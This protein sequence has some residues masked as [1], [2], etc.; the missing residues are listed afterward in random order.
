MTSRLLRSGLL[1]NS[2]SPWKSVEGLWDTRFP[3]C[4]GLVLDGPMFS[5]VCALPSPISAEDCSSLFDRF[6][7]TMAQSDSS[8]ACLSAVWRKAFSDRSR[9]WLS[10]EASE[11]SQFSCM[12]F[13]S[14][15]GFSDYA[16]PACHSRN[17]ATSRVAFP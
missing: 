4:V 14:V 10:R 2:E 3:L 16:G 12:L 8:E 1:V 9:L 7:G 5:L 17:N 11:V 15:R 6:T 13:L